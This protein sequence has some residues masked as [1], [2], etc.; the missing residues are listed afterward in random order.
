MYCTCEHACSAHASM[1]VLHMRA[2][3]FWAYDK[4]K[5]MIVINMSKGFVMNCTMDKHVNI[6]CTLNV[7]LIAINNHLG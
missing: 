6:H 2:C 4:E 7:L 1:Y 5:K 3:M